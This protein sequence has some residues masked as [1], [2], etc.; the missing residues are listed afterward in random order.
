MKLRYLVIGLIGLS[1]ISIF[2]GVADISPL[3]VFN[4]SEDQVEIML[5]G[6]IPRLINILIAG[7]SMSIAGL[8][9]QQLSKNKFVSPT[10][11]GT[12]DA[13]RFGVLVS[14][15]VFTTASPIFKIIV[16]FSFALLGTFIFI[17]RKS[18]RLN[19]SH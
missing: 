8:I 17:D 6:R 18:T 11:A 10:T 3:D 15:M 1:F 2:I 13:A 12:L 5:I 4:L 16:S 9:M 14:L 19:S 7:A